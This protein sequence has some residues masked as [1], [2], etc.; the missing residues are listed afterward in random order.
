MGETEY[1]TNI[2]RFSSELEFLTIA[3]IAGIISVKFV[4]KLYE[5]LYEPML[6]TI[7]PDD[8]C[9]K[10]YHVG[11]VPIRYGILMREFIK[12]VLLIIMLMLIHNYI[13]KKN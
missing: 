7:I 4:N 13:Q 2:F 10:I 1:I 12:W 8:Y 6:H 3:T 11:K 9:L 5:E